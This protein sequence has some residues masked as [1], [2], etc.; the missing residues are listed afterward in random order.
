MT[1]QSVNALPF[2]RSIKRGTRAIYD[3]DRD[4]DIARLKKRIAFRS[5]EA[6]LLRKAKR[7]N[8]KKNP[9]KEFLKQL[10]S[11]IKGKPIDTG[12]QRVFLSP[13]EERKR[14]KIRKGKKTEILSRAPVIS[15][16][17]EFE[18]DPFSELFSFPLELRRLSRASRLRAAPSLISN[19]RDIDSTSFTPVFSIDSESEED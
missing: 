8:E 16:S 13:E 7:R 1:L 9:S 12:E 2:Q 14:R 11:L 17:R 5:Q 4:T 3:N 10:T 6:Q 18:K 19:P 15:S